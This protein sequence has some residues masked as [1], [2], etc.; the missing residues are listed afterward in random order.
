[1]AERYIACT[2]A[3]DG[4]DFHGSQR[5]LNGRSIQGEL[6]RALEVVLKQPAQVQLAGRTDAGV[7]ALGQCCRF[8]TENRIPAE[9]VPYALNSV[10]D[11]AVRV[12]D[13]REVDAE[14]H[15]RF[16]ARSRVYRYW[17]EEPDRD[18]AAGSNPLL[19]RVAGPSRV[20]LDVEA[21]RLAGEP[22]L[23]RQDFAAWQSAGSPAKC[24]TRTIERLTVQRRDDVYGS[25]LV[26][27]EIEADAFLYQMVRN[28]VGA[29]ILAGQRRLDAGDI[30][31][32]TVG[33]DRT[34]CPPPAP[35]QGLCLLQ[36]NY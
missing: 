21:M 3:Y 13:A 27:V 2:V 6:E 15:P 29:L 8:A 36:V 35:P 16:S 34:K 28:I 22:L 12:R 7:H 14:F 5:Q 33:K 9:R 19:R 18:G 23:G 4:T 1:M 10:L 17:I 24:T 26:E 20:R 30:K 31:R 25:T 11:R 32:L